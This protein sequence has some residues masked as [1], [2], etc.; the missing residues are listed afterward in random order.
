M[1]YSV[2]YSYIVIIYNTIYLV[3]FLNFLFENSSMFYEETEG[4][5]FKPFN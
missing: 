3:Y 1:Q 5:P 4:V 2:L